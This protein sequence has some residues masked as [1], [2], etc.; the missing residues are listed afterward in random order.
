MSESCCTGFACW[1]S[2]RRASSLTGTFRSKV[3][4]LSSA[5]EMRHWLGSPHDLF[6]LHGNRQSG[7]HF[8]SC[9]MDKHLFH[10]PLGSRSMHWTSYQWLK[11]RWLDRSAAL[12]AFRCAIQP[13]PGN[14][15]KRRVHAKGSRNCTCFGFMV[16]TKRPNHSLRSA[17]PCSPLLVT[18]GK[19]VVFDA[20]LLRGSGVHLC[21]RVSARMTVSDLG[22]FVECGGRKLWAAQSSGLKLEMTGLA[23]SAVRFPG[24]EARDFRRFVALRSVKRFSIGTSSGV[25]AT[26]ALSTCRDSCSALESENVST[27]QPTVKIRSR[28][29]KD[30]NQKCPSESSTSPG[31][32]ATTPRRFVVVDGSCV[33]FRCFHAVPS[34]TN[35]NGEEVGA[36]VGF[37]R[38]LLQVHSLCSCLCT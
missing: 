37:Y 33:M 27:Q 38:S 32:A 3:R 34:M 11:V 21:R 5:V 24:S 12:P 23:C 22:Q 36:V 35:R 2:A 29:K 28:G 16:R 30:G 26:L 20:D 14:C 8:G 13:T 17:S 6:V 1:R 31:E 7:G 25:G 15:I 10:T 19:T 4:W 18:H 9:L